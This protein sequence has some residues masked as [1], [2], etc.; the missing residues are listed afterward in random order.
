M[1]PLE[2]PPELFVECRKALRLTGVELAAMLGIDW[3]TLARY[4]AGDSRIPAATWLAL[5]LFLTAAGEPKL[6]ARL[7]L[8]AAARSWLAGRATAA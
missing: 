2:P 6:A 1:P 8:P 7:P 5:H 4:E 3:R